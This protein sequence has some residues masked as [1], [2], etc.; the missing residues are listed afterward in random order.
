[1][2]WFVLE[3]RSIEQLAANFTFTSVGTMRGQ[4]MIR[5]VVVVVLVFLYNA[6]QARHN[7]GKITIIFMLHT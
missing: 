1:M 2:T 4:G 5:V 6:P 7:K 3:P